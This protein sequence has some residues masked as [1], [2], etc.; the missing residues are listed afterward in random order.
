MN[1]AVADFNDLI[2]R[3]RRFVSDLEKM[4]N[5]E[6]SEISD[7]LRCVECKIGAALILCDHCEDV[8]CGKCF[9]KIHKNGRR[10]N[11]SRTLL[12]LSMC[13]ECEKSISRVNCMQCQDSFCDTC[14]KDL[15]LRGGRRNHVAAVLSVACA[16]AQRMPVQGR[17]ASYRLKK[18]HSP[19]VQLDDDSGF[20]LFYNFHVSESSRDLPL[21]PL[22]EP[23]DF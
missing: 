1:A 11:H 14:F 13:A 7:L 9:S 15:H 17:S 22:N 4:E 16:A 18:L 5:L 3:S 12:E 23:L 2:D 10:K 20:C 6:I 8:F 19:W 21:E